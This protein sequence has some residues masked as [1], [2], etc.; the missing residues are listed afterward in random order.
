MEEHRELNQHIWS[1]VKAAFRVYVSEHKNEEVSHTNA[2]QALQ[3][4]ILRLRDI[5]LKF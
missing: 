4:T 5:P 2:E 1:A 3:Y